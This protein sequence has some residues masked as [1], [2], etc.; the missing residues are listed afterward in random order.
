MHPAIQCTATCAMCSLIKS[1]LPIFM[2]IV[3]LVFLSLQIF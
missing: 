3:Y 1:D 2:C